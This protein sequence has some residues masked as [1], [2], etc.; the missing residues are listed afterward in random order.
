[1]TDSTLKSITEFFRTEC[2]IAGRYADISLTA[3]LMDG[4]IVLLEKVVAVK[5]KTE[6]KKPGQR[7]ESA[8]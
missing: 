5:E 4:Q 6:A 1:M 8:Y 7:H 3:K 2:S